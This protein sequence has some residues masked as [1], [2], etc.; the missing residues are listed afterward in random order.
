VD[1]VTEPVSFVSGGETLVG[2]LVVPTGPV[3]RRLP[4]VVI[5]GGQTSV[6]EQ[7]AERYANRLA[8]HGYVGLAFDFRGFGESGGRP[9]DY[10]SPGR[11]IEDLRSALSFLADRTTVDPG[12]LAALG[13]GVGAG[14]VAVE[15][16][17]DRRVAA[18]ALV[19]PGLQDGQIV[20]DRYGGAR[21][22]AERRARGEAARHKYEET[23]QVDYEVVVGP[24]DPPGV[25]GFFLNP[26]RGGVPEWSNRFAVLSWPEWLAFD[27]ISAA[28][29]ITV[30]TVMVHSERATDPEAAHLF[31]DQLPGHKTELWTSGIQF[32]FYD[33][34]P[35]VTVA[36]DAIV[37]HLDTTF[38]R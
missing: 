16:A 13:I 32:D 4:A 10:E 15:A 1:T 35:Q 19:A 31:F 8:E 5:A 14:Y 36:V 2:R 29:K 37:E 38:E 12:R 21:G 11:K 9:R 3:N 7:M 17:D 30:P 25:V 27:P 20:R 6:K 18:L 22:V 33:R 23:G 26:D 24:D 34:E 28:P